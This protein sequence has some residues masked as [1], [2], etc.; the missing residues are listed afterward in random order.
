MAYYIDKTKKTAVK[1]EGKNAF[2]WN[3]E[4][5]RFDI[6]TTNVSPKSR[7]TRTSDFEARRYLFESHPQGYVKRLQH[8]AKNVNHA[9]DLVDA[10]ELT[11]EIAESHL[12]AAKDLLH[13]LANEIRELQDAVV[14]YG[15]QMGDSGQLL[16]NC[17]EV[18]KDHI[19]IAE[20]E[21]EIANL[22]NDL[23][24]CEHGMCADCA[25]KNTC[26]ETKRQKADCR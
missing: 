19:I 12:K 5:R 1:F 4:T 26:K 14:A 24:A 10:K 13:R 25:R 23:M 9:F 11:V 16:S 8:L 21:I 17:S 20:T 6:P 7:M 3:G 22:K 15:M 18:L 2:A